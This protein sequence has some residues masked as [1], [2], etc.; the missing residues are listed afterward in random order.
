M[1]SAFDP[2]EFGFKHSSMSLQNTSP[3]PS[4]P[5]LHL[6]R[7]CAGR[8]QHSAFSTHLLLI[9][10]SWHSSISENND[11]NCNIYY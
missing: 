2:H 6:H 5:D 3:S 8:L 1:Q 9:L 4:Y 10:G 7:K 11:N